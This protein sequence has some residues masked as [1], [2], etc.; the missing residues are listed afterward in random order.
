MTKKIFISPNDCLIEGKLE[1]PEFFLCQSSDKEKTK[2][3]LSKATLIEMYKEMLFIRKFEDSLKILKKTNQFNEKKYF[4]DGP[5]HL[6]SG[7]EAA[8]VGQAHALDNMDFSFG[9]HRSHG[10]VIARSLCYIYKASGLELLDMMHNYHN[11]NIFKSFKA[12]LEMDARLDEESRKKVAIISDYLN[13]SNAKEYKKTTPSSNRNDSIIKQIAVDYFFFGLVSEILGKT[14]GL[15]KGVAGSMNVFFTPAGVYPA[16]AIVGASAPIAVGAALKKRRAKN[17]KNITVANLGDASLGCGV[18]HE[19]MNFAAMQQFDTLWEN[20]GNP[21]VLFAFFNNGYGMGGQTIGETMGYDYLI[22]V[23]L[24]V[25]K[26]GLSAKRING[27]DVLDVYEATIKSKEHILSGKGPALLDM[28]VYRYE[29]HSQSDMENCRE[30]CEIEAWQ[31][32]DP[33]VN[34]KKYICEEGVLTEEEDFQIENYIKNTIAKAFDRAIDDNI[35]MKATFDRNKNNFTEESLEKINSALLNCSNYLND[36]IDEDLGVCNY[37]NK[38]RNSNSVSNCLDDDLNDSKSYFADNKVSNVEKQVALVINNAFVKYDDL[39]AYGVN[40]RDWSCESIYSRAIEDFN[41]SRLFN[42]PVSEASMISVA[43]GYAMT[44]GRV[45]V[46]FMFSGFI[47]RAGDEIF[48][49]LAKW[50]KLSGDYFKLPIVIRLA[51]STSYGAQ[52]SQD[53]V[54]LLSHIP[55][56]TIFCPS[57]KEDAIDMLELALSMD[58]P[59]LFFE[60]KDIFDCDNTTIEKTKISP[61]NTINVFNESSLMDMPQSKLTSIWEPKVVLK[62][63]DV[64]IISLGSALDETIKA[65]KILASKGISCEVVDIRCISPM[66]QE[67]M[68]KS[69]MK[70]K[71]VIIVGNENEKTSILSHIAYIIS[72]RCFGHLDKPVEIIGTPETITP[73]A[74][75]LGNYFPTAELI[76]KKA[77][78]L[79]L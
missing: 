21:P 68:I 7:S 6:A 76:A 69:A 36:Y 40:V 47:G 28:V 35:A 71:K 31:D 20:P 73:L 78:E 44:G 48:N 34:F 57:T 39:I 45:L 8:C 50:E 42:T 43:I 75:N 70:T 27:L 60:P 14:T 4:L 46:D 9:S 30:C 17:N 25:N 37:S 67:I 72:K 54:S 55:G 12:T 58:T 33:V 77:L 3:K 15:Q 26:E 59:V 1:V 56:I 79:Y 53:W 18:V 65:T 13:R 51:T 63:S 32:L 5:I 52:H 23:G 19:A 2:N 64:S 66:K 24:G 11:T 62:G 16:N 49:Q 61:N 29:G 10:E 38:C 41:Y 74:T 22:R